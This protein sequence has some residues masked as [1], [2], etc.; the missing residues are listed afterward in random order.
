MGSGIG[1]AKRGQAAFITGLLF[2][3]GIDAVNRALKQPVPFFEGE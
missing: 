3:T 2:R 1:P